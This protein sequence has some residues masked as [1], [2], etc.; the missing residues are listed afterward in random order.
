MWGRTH[1]VWMFLFLLYFLLFSLAL[2]VQCFNLQIIVGWPLSKS[3]WDE[4]G[5]QYRS[6][7]KWTASKGTFIIYM[8][9]FSEMG[10][11]HCFFGYPFLV[12]IFTT[13]PFYQRTIFD[14]LPLNPPNPKVR[15]CLKQPNIVFWPYFNIS[16]GDYIRKKYTTSLFSIKN[17][18]HPNPVKNAGVWCG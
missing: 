5:G 16:C 14:P 17:P 4:F 12:S 6:N 13:L 3:S 1:F 18:P 10:V 15:R 7:S 9:S 8:Q 2:Y 11:S